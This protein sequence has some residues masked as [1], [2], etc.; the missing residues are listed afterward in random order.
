MLVLCYSFLICTILCCN[1]LNK[2]SCTSQCLTGSYLN[3][4]LIFSVAHPQPAAGWTSAI[5]CQERKK[6]QCWFP[7]SWSLRPVDGTQH[8]LSHP[9]AVFTFEKMYSKHIINIEQNVLTLT[10]TTN[11]KLKISRMA[12]QKLAPVNLTRPIPVA[13]Q[14]TGKRDTTTI[15]EK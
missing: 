4:C 2:Y 10:S 7:E 15:K 5:C 9:I 11:N 3:W 12:G 6:P 8:I 13:D 14:L 1:W